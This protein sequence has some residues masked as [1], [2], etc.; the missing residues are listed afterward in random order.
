MSSE[1]VAWDVDLVRDLFNDR[2]ANL[3]LSIPLSLSR[4]VD[5]WFWCWE[6]TGHFSVKS[7]YKQLQLSKN[8]E[9]QQSNSVIWKGIWKLYVPPKVKDLVWRAAS[10]CLPTKTRLRSRHVQVDNGCPRCANHAET[11][12]HCLVDCPF[13]NSCWELTGLKKTVQVVT[14]FAG[15]LEAMFQQLDKDQRADVAVLC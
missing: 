1:D 8:G 9:S 6:K 11:P 12:Y 4:R 3:I 2:D 7:T 10:D 15:W 5:V 14:S 13:A